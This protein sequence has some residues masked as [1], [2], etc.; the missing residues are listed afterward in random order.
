M[1][2]KSNILL[3]SNASRRSI[4]S[5]NYASE[6]IIGV[7][8]CANG[9]DAFFMILRAVAEYV[10]AKVSS[11]APDWMQV[12]AGEAAVRAE[13]ESGRSKPTDM[14]GANPCLPTL[15]L[16]AP[17]LNCA[18][19]FFLGGGGTV[20]A[21]TGQDP[22]KAATPY[23]SVQVCRLAAG[24]RR[25]AVRTCVQRFLRAFCRLQ[26]PCWVR[27]PA[28]LFSFVPLFVGVG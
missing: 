10:D 25:T 2:S 28:R 4:V 7:P 13:N 11:S 6:Q 15:N 26:K 19:A 1:H 23:Y 16:M 14:Q 17:V 24:S 8:A 12:G 3:G 27:V 21:T 20:Y 9:L 18:G 5:G 22:F